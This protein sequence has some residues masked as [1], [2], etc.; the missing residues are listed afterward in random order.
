MKGWRRLVNN[1]NITYVSGNEFL[2]NDKRDPSMLRA[3]RAVD[4][5]RMCKRSHGE[6]ERDRLLTTKSR[7]TRHKVAGMIRHQINSLM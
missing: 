5:Q 1:E 6:C 7:K 2:S 3:L 4:C